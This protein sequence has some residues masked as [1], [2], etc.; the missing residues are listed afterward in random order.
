MTTPETT[1]A[2]AAEPEVLSATE[3]QALL[4]PLPEVNPAAIA[5][6]QERQDD[7]AKAAPAA[8]DPVSKPAAAP[9]GK[10]KSKAAAVDVDGRTFD[11]LLHECTPQGEPIFRSDGKTLK[12]RRTPLK[13]WKQTSRVGF[14]D[15]FAGEQDAPGA[16]EAEPV[17]PSS[18]EMELLASAA[19][20]AGLQ[21]MLMKA[22][23]G[24]R[25]GDDESER[26][27][28]VSAWVRVF[29]HYGLGQLHPVMGLA[30]VSG[31]IVVS[32][33]R[34]EETVSRFQK[35]S[36]WVQHKLLS[37]WQWLRGRRGRPAETQA[38]DHKQA[39]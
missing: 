11:P 21:L 14:D 15:A 23:L 31:G 27:Q 34:H 18:Q 13:E 5:A 12:K 2:P 19:T 8:A 29:Q 17:G 22:A 20:L 9:G 39:A 30:M 4:D 28:L 10:P 26:Q 38:E 32:A 24:P 1:E 35:L 16:K 37:V 3:A 33:L 36:H 6:E 25:L 7:A